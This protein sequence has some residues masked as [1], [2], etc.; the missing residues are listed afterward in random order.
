MD[1]LDN[2]ILIEEL[3][4]H[5]LFRLYW[6]RQM[7]EELQKEIV[8]SYEPVGEMG[9]YSKYFEYSAPYIGS[10]A[11]LSDTIAVIHLSITSNSQDYNVQKAVSGLD[12]FHNVK[13]RIYKDDDLILTCKFRLW[14]KEEEEY[15]GTKEKLE[16]LLT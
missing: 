8:L 6:S 15:S 7:E 14:S 16:F 3:R 9:I 11:N 2:N 4:R 1:F 12:F 5:K 13:I 10:E